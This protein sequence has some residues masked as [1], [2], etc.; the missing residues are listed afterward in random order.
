[1]LALD[2]K[3]LLNLHFKGQELA[4]LLLKPTKNIKT[5]NNLPKKETKNPPLFSKCA[6]WISVTQY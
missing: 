3:I 2:I 1:M 4:Y 5:P 6:Q